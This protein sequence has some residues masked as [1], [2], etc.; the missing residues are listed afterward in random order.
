MQEDPNIIVLIQARTGST[1]LPN[2]I[3]YPVKGKTL[4]ELMIERVQFSHYGRKIVVMTTTREEDDVIERICMK[5]K[6]NCFRGHETDLV[7]RH[8]QA[9]AE[10]KAGIVV[11]IPSDCPLIDPNIIDRVIKYYLE[12][13]KSFDFVSNLHPATYPDG[14]DVEVFPFHI[15]ET[16]WKEAIKDYERE[17]TTPFIW[18]NPKRFRIGNV[19]WEKGLD[20]SMKHR[21][22]LDYMDDYKLIKAI[23][24]E[25]Y[26]DDPFFDIK[27][28]IELIDARPDLKSLNEKYT[29]VNWYRD[30]LNELK[31]VKP[32]QTRF[33]NHIA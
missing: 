23:Y 2:K 21:W 26:D 7:D 11:K 8:Y 22:T 13:V 18:D 4:L 33:L 30:H 14:N 19:V 31:T 24:D 27:D 16:A 25:F 28:I 6:I 10:Y 9:A 5:N 29:G 32:D 1:R 15:L 17:H 3:L 20:Y 12:N